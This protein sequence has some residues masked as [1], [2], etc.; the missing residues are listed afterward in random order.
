MSRE[1]GEEKKVCSGR[2]G[3][4][5]RQSRGIKGVK[6]IEDECVTKE[7]RRTYQA[8]TPSRRNRMCSTCSCYCTS[9]ED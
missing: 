7:T 1:V 5:Q 3:G 6:A 8:H 2:G 4:L 9:K